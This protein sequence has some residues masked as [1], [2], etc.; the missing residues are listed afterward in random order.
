ME[1]IEKSSSITFIPFNIFNNVIKLQ[2]NTS[3]TLDNYFYMLNI[4]KVV[5]GAKT[6]K[7]IHGVLDIVINLFKNLIFNINS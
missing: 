7:L 3:H 6:E 4:Y 5:D 2:F 1:E